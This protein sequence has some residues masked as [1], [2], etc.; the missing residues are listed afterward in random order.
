MSSPVPCTPCCTTPQVTNIPGAP[1][2]NGVGLAGTNGVNAY[3]LTTADFVVPITGNNV[4]I[5]V[6]S[7]AFMVIGQVLIIGQGAGAA[8][9]NP[10]PMTGQ[11]VTIP[12]ASS[13]QVKALGYAG[14]VVAGTTI[15]TG[16]N[17]GTA[18]VSPSGLQ[19]ASPIGIANGGTGQTTAQ[20]AANALGSRYRLLTSLIGANFN[21]TGDQAMTGLPNKWVVRRIIVTNASADL[22]AATIPL[23]GVY[24]APA[25][26]GTAIVAAG[27]SYAPLSTAAKWMDLT[28]AAAVLTGT[29]ILTATTIYLSLSTA[30]GAAATADV[31]VF[32]ED[33]T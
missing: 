30:H 14:D 21:S 1:G 22:S 9:A 18:V 15:G 27:Q 31:Y 4:T 12:G 2:V 28:L 11:V 20:A 24:T 3:T 25:K 29:D 7:T 19:T 26:G 10:G 6:L 13:V 17:L 16:T 33:L 23:G 8:L 5:A 32:G